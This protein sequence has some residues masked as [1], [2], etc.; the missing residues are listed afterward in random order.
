MK[1]LFVLTCATLAFGLLFS[2]CNQPTSGKADNEQAILETVA[3]TTEGCCGQCDTEINASKDSKPGCCGK[4]AG[5]S[6]GAADDMAGCQSG[7]NGCVE[8]NPEDCKCGHDTEQSLAADES[9]VN[10]MPEDRDIFHFLLESHDK[11]TRTVKPLD[12]GVETITESTDPAVASKI[13]EHVASMKRRVED[14]RPLRMWDELYREI[15]KHSDKIKMEIKNTENGISVTETSDDQYVVKLIQEHAKV[16]TGFSER[17]FE[18]ARENH[19]P[20][21]K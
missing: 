8:T 18:E 3:G 2:G 19:I 7:C 14:G 16:V 9:H 6:E 21:K 15:F 11:I 17:G 20:P 12:N 1:N 4:C 10:S 5:E 13:R